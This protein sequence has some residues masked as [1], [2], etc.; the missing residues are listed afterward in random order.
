MS[1][2]ILI[3]GPPR[4]GKTTLITQLINNYLNKN[5][6]V[7]GFLTPEVREKGKRI[8]F[9][10][11]NIFSRERKILARIGDCHKSLKLGKYCIFIENLDNMIY[12]LEKF[13]FKEIDLL[14]ID[15]IGK[16][17]LFS[18]KFQKFIKEIFKSELQL[19]ATIGETLKH[20]I[21]EYILQ[22]SDHITFNLIEE[23]HANIFQKI[24]TLIK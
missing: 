15:E 16:M 19:I 12:D 20:P 3:T 1:S 6:K 10:I 8:G 9:D 4:C 13:D 7:I 22:Q 2:K 17:E 5:Y 24:L 14:V 23:N 18:K 21:K 11:Q